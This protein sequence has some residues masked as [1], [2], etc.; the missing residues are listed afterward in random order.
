MQQIFI[1]YNFCL[2][3]RLLVKEQELKKNQ[4]LRVEKQELIENTKQIFTG[5]WKGME[6]TR[7]SNLDV[8]FIKIIFKK[9]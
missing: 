2:S 9:T 1:F 3:L 6:W 4:K 5:V 7:C 8:L